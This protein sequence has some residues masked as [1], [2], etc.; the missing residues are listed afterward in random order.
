MSCFSW[1]LYLRSNHSSSMKNHLSSFHMQICSVERQ[2][3]LINPQVL[4]ADY[5]FL[6]RAAVHCWRRKTTKWKKVWKVQWCC[7]FF[8][9]AVTLHPL[10]KIW[11]RNSYAFD[12][13][14]R[15]GGLS[16]WNWNWEYEYVHIRLH[17][18]FW[19]N[20]TFP[21][22]FSQSWHK[23]FILRHWLFVV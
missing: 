16:L 18:I 9:D 2:R 14:F 23:S 6:S 5:H 3:C 11:H 12:S 7:I 15:S 21:L 22:Y 8:C 4:L 20:V 10:N 19:V 1:Q 13:F 17:V